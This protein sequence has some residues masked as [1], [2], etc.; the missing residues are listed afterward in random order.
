MSQPAH[1][2]PALECLDSAVVACAGDIMLDRFVYGAVNRISPEAP[3]PVLRLESQH[4]ALGGLGNV[5]RNLGALGCRSRLFAVTGQDEAGEEIQA[6]MREVPGCQAYLLKEP[7]RA[8]PVKTRYIAHGQQLLRADRESTETADPAVIRSLVQSFASGLS[9]CSVVLLSDYAKGTLKGAHAQEFIG[10]ARAAGKPVVVDPKGLAFERYRGATVIKPNLKELAEAAG[11]AVVDAASQEAA[12]RKLLDITAAQFIL[13]TRG[14]AGMLLVSP[15][16]P[17]VQFAS[18]AREV[19]DV[20]GAGDT[21]AAVLAAALGSGATPAEAAG[22]ASVAAGIVVGKIGTAVVDRTEIIREIERDSAVAAAGKI[23]GP[24]EALERQ[25][26]WRRA[27]A[28][29]GFAYG[30]FHPL[31]AKHL[32]LLELVRSRCGR[33]IAGLAVENSSIAPEEIRARALLLA[34]LL[35]VDAVVICDH[36]PHKFIENLRP[37]V[38]AT[39]PSAED[40]DR[41]RSL[42]GALI[43]PWSGELLLEDSPAP[44]PALHSPASYSRWA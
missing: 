23:L 3:I 6:L 32:R 35:Q 17:P 39:A 37:D 29:T 44:E 25:R 43:E 5:V 31:S 24:A 38:I 8:T 10:A 41:Q 4:A 18:P 21:V 12:C 28:R 13:L 26:I 42:L 34:S 15:D 30:P 40:R 16:R 22:L 2:L 20:S 7:S 36:E 33:L 27:G 1:L 9:D 11:M 14:A 19:Y